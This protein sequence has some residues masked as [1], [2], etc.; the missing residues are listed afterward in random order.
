MGRQS[1]GRG[2]GAIL[3]DHRVFTPEPESSSGKGLAEVDLKLIDPNPFQP[4]R[5]FRPEEIADLAETIKQHGLLQP[6]SLRKVGERYQI[7]AGERR[8]R[9]CQQL[10]LQTISAQVH[11]RMSDKKMAEWALIENIQRVDLSAIEEARA[12]HQLIQDHGYRHEDLAQALGKS[13]SGITNTLRL[14][15]LPEEIQQWVHEGKLSA[16]HARN[17]LSPEVTDPLAMAREIMESGSS[18]R[19]TEKMRK[20]KKQGKAGGVVASPA[21]SAQ[22]IQTAKLETEWRD[23]LGSLVKIK[24]AGGKGRIEILFSD[25]EEFNRLHDLICRRS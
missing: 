22:A 9:A 16:S 3:G 24:E 14:T 5:E 2:L 25:F 23:A 8:F 7:I 20:E 1:L 21:P 4:R 13:R 18:V 11:E 17:L 6:I 10:G 15:H 12:Y 19:Q